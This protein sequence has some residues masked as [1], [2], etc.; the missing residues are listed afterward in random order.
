MRMAAFTALAIPTAS[1]LAACTSGYDDAP[2]PLRPLWLRASADAKA[3]EA[4][5]ASAPESAD[6]AREL[7]TIRSAHAEVLRMEVER[8][9]RPV[10]ENGDPAPG[11]TVDGID[12]LWTRIAEARE[13]ALRLVDSV[14]RY[15]AGLVGAVSAG[16]AA[17]QQ[18]G[19]NGLEPEPALLG[20]DSIDSLDDDSVTA[21]QSA[22]AAEHAA[23]W[24]Y[25]LARA[26]LG[27][28]YENGITRGERAHI[29]R[30]D[31]CQRVLSEAGHTPRPTEPAYVLPEE[32]TDETSA[33]LAVAT[34]ESDAATAWHGVLERT[35]DKTVRTLAVKCLTGA[36][37]RG[38]HWRREA[39]LQPAVPPLPGRE[40]TAS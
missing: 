4:L 5:A 10:P 35:D 11:A 14:P 18:L 2:D 24:V 28:G 33:A 21:L 34:A 6:L 31:A 30:R 25:G 9:N 20:K 7:A 13:E 3:A 23:I 32:V 8:L 40:D 12:A 1:G 22:L 27:S 36:A 19:T 17:A 29:N 37:T 16:C 26:F 38:V 15:R 39:G